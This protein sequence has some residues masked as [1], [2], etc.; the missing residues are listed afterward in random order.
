MS[1][2]CPACKSWLASGQFVCKKCGAGEAKSLLAVKDKK[3]AETVMDR[4]ARVHRLPGFMEAHDKST[5]GAL[6]AEAVALAKQ[7][8]VAQYWASSDVAVLRVVQSAST[9]LLQL[10]LPHI[11]RPLHTVAVGGVSVVSFAIMCGRLSC[12]KL[13]LA[14]LSRLD[15][16]AVDKSGF[17]PFDLCLQVQKNLSQL[18]YQHVQLVASID[19]G[20]DGQIESEE[21]GPRGWDLEAFRERSTQKNNV[22]AALIGE[23]I[24]FVAAV[25]GRSDSIGGVQGMAI[26][27]Q[28]AAVAG[29]VE[30]PAPF[31][32]VVWVMIVA[33]CDVETRAV[34]LPCVCRFFRNLSFGR[35]RCV[36][37]LSSYTFP[38]HILADCENA[39]FVMS[40]CKATSGMQSHLRSARLSELCRQEKTIM[41]LD[42]P[43]LVEMLRT[44]PRPQGELTGLFLLVGLIL[45]SGSE[46]GKKL[47]T[48][49]GFSVK[50]RL[51]I[52][53]FNMLSEVELKVGA[54]AVGLVRFSWRGNIEQ[55]GY[56]DGGL[57]AKKRLQEGIDA[58][59]R[60]W[61]VARSLSAEEFCGVLALVCEAKA[62]MCADS[63]EFFRR[64]L[65]DSGDG[66]RIAVSEGVAAK[67]S[68]KGE[69]SAAGEVTMAQALRWEAKELADFFERNGISGDEV[70]KSRLSGRTFIEATHYGAF[71]ASSMGPRE[72]REMVEKIAQLR[73]KH[74][75]SREMTGRSSVEVRGHAA[76]N[77]VAR[78]VKPPAKQYFNGE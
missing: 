7:S 69:E 72:A 56:C 74:F 48:A 3:A 17:A 75:A 37:V 11:N 32:R 57:A 19:F 58:V 73:N 61:N 31:P 76:A 43:V 20:I 33:A 50:L 49:S 12:L 9:E 10:V 5:W 62:P 13:L 2:K 41:R 70:R 40:I 35:D 59:A 53:R 34:L 8:L 77:H 38:Q 65:C 30:T 24:A 39:A 54:K 78:I 64:L 63:L 68:T 27:A 71:H 42:L 25:T 16:N 14:D 18:Q 47:V 44:P 36:E 28:K 26:R 29:A 1:R 51:S 4:L 45:V 21:D 22:R 67:A 46:L 60:M 15:V 52:G 66:L 55:L 23:M 6:V